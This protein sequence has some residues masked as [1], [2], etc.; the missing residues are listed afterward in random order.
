MAVSLTIFWAAFA[1]GCCEGYGIVV[2]VVPVC[3]APIISPVC[4]ETP[5]KTG[6]TVFPELPSNAGAWFVKYT[7][8]MTPLFESVLDCSRASL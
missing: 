4:D 5:E 8:C 6:S 7:S 2:T 1:C 3:A